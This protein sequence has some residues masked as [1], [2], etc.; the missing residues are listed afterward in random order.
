MRNKIVTIS[1]LLLICVFSV[2]TLVA[3]DRSFSDIENR[4]L[5]QLPVPSLH[6]VADGAFMKSFEKYMSDQIV[7]KDELVK[8]MVSCE[9][10]MGQTLINDVYFAKNGTLL[11]SFDKPDKTLED[12]LSYIEEFAADNE[13][14][15]VKWFLIPNACEIYSDELPDYASCYSQSFVLNNIRQQ[16]KGVEIYDCQDELKA[17]ADDYIYYKTDHH[18]TMD[19]AYIGYRKLAQCLG[20]RVREKD[21]YEI[22]TA[23]DD[24]LGSLY[25]KAPTFNENFDKIKLY[26][27]SGDYELEFEDGSTM[28]GFYKYENLGIKD[29]YT[30]YMDGNHS[31]VKIKNRYSNG[32]SL[33]ILKDSYAHC[34]IP[35]LA[36]YYSE[37]YVVDLRYYHRSVS[38]LARQ[39]GIKDVLLINN[40]DFVCTDNSYLWLK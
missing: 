17:A 40:I 2:G 25:S 6:T 33:L 34:L 32:D 16:V 27:I 30:V 28:E 24:F 21:S 7:F 23:A 20:L 29:K 39:N 36:E 11:Q 4:N 26:N 9:R 31:L 3:K 15:R 5:E 18:W 38:E 22:S 19:G 12:N 1:F 13:D 37:I 14:L 8:L 10:T 35:F